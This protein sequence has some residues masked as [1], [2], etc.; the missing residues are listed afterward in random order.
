[1]DDLLSKSLSALSDGLASATSLLSSFSQYSQAVVGNSEISITVQEFFQ[2]LSRISSKHEERQFVQRH[3]L[4]VQSILPEEDTK[5]G[6]VREAI[7]KCICCHLLGYDVTFIYIYALKLAQ[8]GTL[9]DKK[10]GYLAAALF[11]SSEHELAILLVNTIQRDL[12]S[13][14]PLEIACAL[15]AAGALLGIDTIPAVLPL[16]CDR[17]RHSNA[18][19]RKKAVG[20][21]RAFLRTSPVLQ[22]EL[23]GPLRLALR[24]KDPAVMWSSLHV[25]GDLVKIAPSAYSD[26]VPSLVSILRQ[27]VDRNLPSDFDYLNCPAP[28]L[29]IRL[30]QLLACLGKGNQNT[31]TKMYQILAELM[32]RFQWQSSNAALAVAAECC[33]TACTIHPLDTLMTTSS[34]YA[35]RLL[36][37]CHG[38]TVYMG[39]KILSRLAQ[40]QRLDLVKPYQLVLVEHLENKDVTLQKQV[41]NLLYEIANSSN[42]EVV[43]S[44]FLEHLTK[45]AGMNTD[46]IHKMFVL[47][48]RCSPTASWFVGKF[49]MLLVKCTTDDFSGAGIDHLMNS[50]VGTM[51][52]VIPRDSAWQ[53]ELLNELWQ[54]L[55]SVQSSDGNL[56]CFIAVA[57]WAAARLCS[58]GSAQPGP[59]WTALRLASVVLG[60][61]R[62][63]AMPTARLWLLC[64]VKRLL[65]LA[66]A[67][68]TDEE[69]SCTS[70]EDRQ[71]FASAAERQQLDELE[72]LQR[73][74]A[75]LRLLREKLLPALQTRGELVIDVSFLPVP[76]VE[77]DASASEPVQLG[78]FSKGHQTDALRYTTYSD[79]YRHA[80]HETSAVTMSEAQ[81]KWLD[82]KSGAPIRRLWTAEGR[83][84]M[85]PTEVQT[86]VVDPEMHRKQQLAAELFSSH[87]GIL[88]KGSEGA[89][90]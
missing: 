79:S 77:P 35:G 57:S 1:M 66:T 89:S 25:Y 48:E 64:T 17:L 10:I 29:V 54:H 36:S 56:D 83:K 52:L 39:L 18:Y 16:V 46:I 84:A 44:K 85:S 68:V 73:L 65:L 43:F 47:L 80:Q 82:R 51:E 12:R 21:L 42:V 28:F 78:N 88:A 30:L 37:S 75:R 6:A 69:L 15:T 38:N 20:C 3:L 19:V 67:T 24:D 41:L 11:L 9:L 61:A 70:P 40:A 22:E 27:V 5:P 74:G 50:A 32:E 26:I 2:Q 59:D 63:M 13:A 55:T 31:S 60:H 53:Q 72:T 23:R 34:Q 62:R 76:T 86:Q 14:Q 4:Q 71:I 87:I 58:E 90:S 49:R 8:C 45:V 7:V 81:A 33:L